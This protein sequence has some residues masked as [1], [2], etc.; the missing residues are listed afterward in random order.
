MAKFKKQQLSIEETLGQVVMP[1]IDF[2][3]S[4]HMDNSIK[5]VSDYNVAGFIVFNGEIEQV[6]ETVLHLQSISSLP[7]FFGCDAERGL[8]QIVR[9][10]TKFP[11]IMSQGAADNS[12]LLEKQ[13]EVTA[14]EMKYSGLN[15]IF[16]PVLDINSNPHNPIINVRSFGDDPDNVS[17]LANIYLHKAKKCGLLTCGKHFPGHGSTDIDSHISL[18]EINKELTDLEELEFLPFISAIGSGVEF[19]MVGHIAIPDIAG[20]IIPAIMSKT[21]VQQILKERLQFNKIVIT[22]SFRMDSLNNF[23]DEIDIAVNS[24]NAGCN[25]ILDPKNPFDLVDKIKLEINNNEMLLSK[26]EASSQ[27]VL[28]LKEGLTEYAGESK[29]RFDTNEE[30]VKKISAES[31]CIIKEGTIDSDS[32]EINLLDVT[33]IG[34]KLIQPFKNCIE[35][36]GIKIN[37]VNN[38]SE[39]NFPEYRSENNIINIV[40]TSVSAWSGYSRLNQ[41]FR[42]FLEKIPVSGDKN[43]LVSLGSPY[44]VKG[45]NHFDTIICSFDSLSAC[46]MAVAENLLGISRSAA[47]LPVKI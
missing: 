38:I 45:M 20:G 34:M 2:N 41:L 3:E 27:T 12:S 8:G 5:L 31:V 6:R 43:I 44:V 33:D 4:G 21:F 24:I 39:N 14:L 7:L 40:V 18:P 9:G 25:I 28:D 30:L 13:A 37:K 23:G 29:T 36:N 46:Q 35:S 47:K 11:F 15:L 22:D 10:G 19:I 16:A 1:R 32:V 42:K 17:R 26:I